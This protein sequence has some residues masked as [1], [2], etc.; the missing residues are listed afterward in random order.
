MIVNDDLVFQVVVFVLVFVVFVVDN[1]WLLCVFVNGVEE[2]L[3]GVVVVG[4]VVIVVVVVVM[5]KIVKVDVL[6]S[7]K[8]VVYGKI[9]MKIEVKV[10]MKVEVCKYCKEQQVEFVQV[11]KCCEVMFI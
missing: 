1:S 10:D 5:F 4:V 3:G 8:V 9:D 2:G 7:M 11:K 6:K